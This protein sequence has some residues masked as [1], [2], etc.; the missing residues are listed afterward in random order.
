MLDDKL[1]VSKYPVCSLPERSS[2]RIWVNGT[3]DP[4]DTWMEL[5]TAYLL[6]AHAFVQSGEVCLRWFSACIISSTLYGRVCLP[7]CWEVSW[8]V[9]DAWR[10]RCLDAKG[11]R[12]RICRTIPSQ[13]QTGQRKVD[14]CI[15]VVYPWSICDTIADS[16][17]FNL[18]ASTW[19]IRSRA[20][21][22]SSCVLSSP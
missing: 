13:E 2:Y 4:R 10:A 7:F 12:M 3:I 11:E 15:K 8:N 19:A 1:A 5:A 22:T 21:L 14:S 17:Q 16:I 6:I 18:S 20:I 9:V